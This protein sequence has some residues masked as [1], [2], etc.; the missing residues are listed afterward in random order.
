MK[1]KVTVQVKTNYNSTLNK[2]AALQ[3]TLR[4]AADLMR[5]IEQDT[6]FYGDTV[7]ASE[8]EDEN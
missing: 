1:L 7:E 3:E 4:K 5:S 6:A 8:I 2:I